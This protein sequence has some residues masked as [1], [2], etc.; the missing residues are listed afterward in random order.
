MEMV[1]PGS[2][3]NGEQYA[4]VLSLIEVQVSAPYSRQPK[5]NHLVFSISTEMHVEPE[6]LAGEPIREGGDK[7]NPVFQVCASKAALVNDRAV[8]EGV[9]GN[10]GCIRTIQIG[11]QSIHLGCQYFKVVLT[12]RSTGCHVRLLLVTQAGVG[13]AAPTPAGTSFGQCASET[14]CPASAPMRKTTP[15]S[16][17]PR[18]LLLTAAHKLARI[19]FLRADF[20]VGIIKL[21]AA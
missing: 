12:G 13:H 17:W 11:E 7:G 15:R 14:R 5:T 21:Q 3:R 16:C 19:L 6:L 20:Y 10:A 4:P 18:R 8:F 2:Q 9:E 1:M